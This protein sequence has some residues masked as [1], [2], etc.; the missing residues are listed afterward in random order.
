MSINFIDSGREMWLSYQ[1][2]TLD[3]SILSKLCI[4]FDNKNK[5]IRY[6][7]EKLPD[8]LKRARPTTYPNASLRIKRVFTLLQSDLVDDECDGDTLVFKFA[9]LDNELPDYFRVKGDIFSCPQDLLVA[10]GIRLDWRMF[11]VG[12][13]RRTSVI[14][15][16]SSILDDSEKQ[17]IIGG[18]NEKAIPLDEFMDLVDKFPTTTSLERYGEALIAS[19]IQDFLNIKKD[20]QAQLNRHLSR[21]Q[22]RLSYRLGNPELDMNRVANLSVA[23]QQLQDLLDKNDKIPEELW[24]QGILD[25][26][27]VLFPQYVTVIPKAPIEDRI[28]GKR[29][30]IDFLLVDASGNVDVLEIKRAFQKNKLL[31]IQTYRDNYVPARELSGGISQ[32]EKYIHLLLNWSVAGEK[33]LTRRY[34]HLLPQGLKI[35]FLTPRGILLTGGCTFN[36]TEQRDF[37][38]IRRQYAHI[39]DIITYTDLLKRLE[40]MIDAIPLTDKPA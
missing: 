33:E 5:L 17:I 31:M 18:E 3:D 14:K 9:Y 22:N 10:K 32:I 1:P 13:E 26:I 27:P 4:D 34:S 28:T 38:L 11:C 15:T 24:Q 12:Y 2:H 37:D 40:T 8:W 29:R 39:A 35:R 30:V 7:P 6:S 20:Y 25:I 19:Y 21:K 16:M 23:R 36:E